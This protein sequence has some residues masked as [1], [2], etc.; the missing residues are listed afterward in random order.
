LFLVLDF[1]TFSAL[2]VV[3]VVEAELLLAVVLAE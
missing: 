2:Q 1:L 3:E